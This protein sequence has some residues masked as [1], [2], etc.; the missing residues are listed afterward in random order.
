MTAH[1][2]TAPVEDS[3]GGF[4]LD[5]AARN[6]RGVIRISEKTVTKIVDQAVRSVPGV[7]GRDGGFEKITGR[8]YPRYNV[9]VDED[10]DAVAVEAFIAATWPA[11][12]IRVA[13]EVRAAICERVAAM[14]GMKVIRA[15]VTV[16]TVVDSEERI[17]DADLDAYRAV[18]SLTPV[19]RGIDGPFKSVITTPTQLVDIRVADQAELNEISTGPRLK[20][21]SPVSTQDLQVY[22]PETADPIELTEIVVADQKPLAEITVNNPKELIPVEVPAPSKLLD[23]VV[24]EPAPLASVE[25][26][27]AENLAAIETLPVENLKNIGVTPTQKRVVEAPQPQPLVPVKTPQAAPLTEITVHTSKTRRIPK[28]TEH[29]LMQISAPDTHRLKKPSVPQLS[30]TPIEVKSRIVKA[31]ET[32]PVEVASVEPPEPYPLRDINISPM[33]IKAVK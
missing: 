19:H 24:P 2:D 13:E 12:I 11:P 32:N 6:E 25:A 26:L 1:H 7:T 23:I 10:G 9:Q 31:V 15:N 4:Q 17:T 8:S 14:L 28:P 21:A 16:E 3:T 29:R 33:N 30:V 5:P 18:P 20:V 22:S 27:P